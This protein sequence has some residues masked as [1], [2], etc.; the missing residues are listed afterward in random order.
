MDMIGHEA[1]ADYRRILFI[2][3][4]LQEIKIHIAVFRAEKYI[5]SII[6][7]LDDMMRES[8][9]NRPGYSWHGK[10]LPKITLVVKNM[11]LA[12]MRSS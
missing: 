1:V 5:R 6:A 10:S 8:R 7:S 11:G 3:V 9:R 4:N 2:S 12:Y